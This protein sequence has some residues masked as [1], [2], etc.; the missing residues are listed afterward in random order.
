MRIVGPHRDQTEFEPDPSR[1][2]RRGRALDA[3]LRG[4]VQPPAR[5]A[6]RGIFE[7]FEREDARRWQAAAQRIN[8]A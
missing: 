6:F 4:A 2:F 1:A 7:R 3:M 5:G 8:A